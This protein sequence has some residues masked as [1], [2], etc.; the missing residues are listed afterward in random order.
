MRVLLIS[1]SGRP[2]LR[3]RARLGMPYADARAAGEPFAR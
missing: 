3:E 1:H 2:Y